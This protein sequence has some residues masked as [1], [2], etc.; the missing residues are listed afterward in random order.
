ME[1]SEYFKLPDFNF[2]T[3]LLDTPSKK[4][5]RFNDTKIY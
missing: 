4:R 5:R 3:D 2:Y 1:M